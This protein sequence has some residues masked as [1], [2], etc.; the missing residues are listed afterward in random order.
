METSGAEEYDDALEEPDLY[1]Y[2]RVPNP[3]YARDTYKVKAEIPTFNGNV[4]IEGCLDWLYEVETFFE[5]MEVPE[6]LRVPL[7]AYKLK[8]GAGA[9]WHRVQ[10]ERRLRG[11]PCVRTVKE[12]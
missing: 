10:E 1:A 9:W 2:R 4:D 6:D 12:Y 5:V 3:T 7:V 11:E 8:G